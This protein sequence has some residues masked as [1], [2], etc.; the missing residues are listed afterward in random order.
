MTL[1]KKLKT[2]KTT[3]GI[4]ID[5]VTLDN[6]LSA[7]LDMAA[8]EILNWMY[9]NHP[10]DRPTEPEVPLRY[11]NV[12]IQGVVYGYNH[13]GAEGETVHNENG[14]N[15]TFVYADMLDYIRS[16]VFQLI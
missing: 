15:R 9:I 12:Q 8:N 5:D 16:N 13:K 7:Y 14:I 1:E 11:E 10:S 2:I 6:E 3:L 4:S